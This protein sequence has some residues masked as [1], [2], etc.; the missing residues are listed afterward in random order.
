[1][2]ISKYPIFFKQWGEWMPIDSQEVVDEKSKVLSFESENIIYRMKR[3]GKKASGRVLE[4]QTWDQLP[5]VR[6]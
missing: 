1:M 5:E 2:Y 3:T 6:N 4:G